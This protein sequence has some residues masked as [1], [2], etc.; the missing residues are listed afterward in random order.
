L[1]TECEGNIVSFL[2]RGENP[3]SIAEIFQV[4]HSIAT[5]FAP[6]CLPLESASALGRKRE[7]LQILPKSRQIKCQNL[8]FLVS[9]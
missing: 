8:I 7:K 4:S 2:G 9:I 6:T 3:R 5:A 1:R